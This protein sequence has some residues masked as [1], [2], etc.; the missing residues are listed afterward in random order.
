MSDN[1]TILDE[2]LRDA[3]LAV[4]SFYGAALQPTGPA[5]R[6]G[7]E[8]FD[9]VGV[10]GF[11]GAGVRGTL[12]IAGSTRLV[13]ATCPPIEGRQLPQRDQV[14][15]WLGELSNLVLGRIKCDLALYG[16]TVGLATPVAFTGEHLRLGAVRDNR[17][18]SWDFVSSEGVVRAWLETEMEPGILLVPAVD[19]QP[20]L[21]SGEPILF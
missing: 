12:V 11:S 14:R 6:L 3:M 10:I 20:E 5:S 18:R 1:D 19:V 8:G 15:D 7:V 17:T 13:I 16:L 4:F 9:A 2:I 21:A